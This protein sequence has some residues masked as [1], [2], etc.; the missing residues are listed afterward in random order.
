MGVL[1]VLGGFLRSPIGKYLM[2]ALG[3]L[4]VL[5]LANRCGHASGVRE[6]HA[7][8][9]KA[10]EAAR[11]EIQRREV[12]SAQ[13]SATARADLGARQEAVAARTQTIIKRIPVYVTRQANARCTVP[14]GFV[15]VFNAAAE[16]RETGVA[17]TPGGSA[18]APSGLALS[19]VADATAGNFGIC[20]AWREEAMTWRRW[21][22]DQKT[23]WDKR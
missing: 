13:I 10:Q 22:A 3:C 4:S 5:L 16:G 20:Y 9:A 8:D 6:E 18:D 19:T 17:G 7:R 14:S 15:S 12:R 11:R 21:Y 23:A 1:M 2:L